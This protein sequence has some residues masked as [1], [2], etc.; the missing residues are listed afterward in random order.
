MP[1]NYLFLIFFSAHLGLSTR[2]ASS[3][4]SRDV[5]TR[6]SH[7][8][9]PAASRSVLKRSRLTSPIGRDSP[10]KK[11]SKV[12]SGMLRGRPRGIGL[13]RR[14]PSSPREIEKRRIAEMKKLTTTDG[15]WAASSPA[16]EG[17]SL[18]VKRRSSSSKKSSTTTTPDVSPASATRKKS[19]GVT[20][21]GIGSALQIKST[22]SEKEQSAGNIV[23]EL[24]RL[25]TTDGF[26]SP[27]SI[28]SDSRDAS[29][30][31]TSSSL[32]RSF[33]QR[34]QQKKGI[35]EV[36]NSLASENQTLTA[37][38]TP[39]VKQKNT[40]KILVRHSSAPDIVSPE[41]EVSK[42][43]RS[44]TSRASFLS[45]SLKKKSLLRRSPTRFGK[46]K[47]AYHR[48]MLSS[49]KFIATRRKEKEIGRE[50]VESPLSNE[51]SEES[52]R[53]L[54]RRKLDEEESKAMEDVKNSHGLRRR[55]S[56]AGTATLKA[57]P[58]HLKNKKPVVDNAN[59][60]KEKELSKRSQSAKISPASS[61]E[62]RSR[63]TEVGLKTIMLETRQ[64]R[65]KTA[66]DEIHSKASGKEKEVLTARTA[67]ETDSLRDLSVVS[68]STPNSSS[69]LAISDLLGSGELKRLDTTPGFW[70]P[71]PD[72]SRVL[73]LSY[74]RRSYGSSPR[75]SRHAAASKCNL[76]P[77][78]PKSSLLQL[79][80]K[81]LSALQKQRQIKKQ[82]SKEEQ[83]QSDCL[84]QQ[85]TED[86]TIKKK[87]FVFGRK[88]R[89]HSKRTFLKEE[90]LS[91]SLGSSSL[92]GHEGKVE[93]VSESTSDDKVMLSV[94]KNSSNLLVSQS[95][96]VNDPSKNFESSFNSTSNSVTTIARKVE[97][98]T[99]KLDSEDIS[100]GANHD[101]W[102]QDERMS[103]LNDAT[104]TYE[105][106]CDKV[107]KFTFSTPKKV[108]PV[109]A[110]SVS[111]VSTL[112]DTVETISVSH[113]ADK[114]EDTLKIGLMS[115]ESPVFDKVKAIQKKVQAGSLCN[116][117]TVTDTAKL[118]QQ[119][120]EID[121]PSKETKDTDK[122]EQI[123][124]ELDAGPQV[125]K[126]ETI[127]ADTKNALNT[128]DE[129][130][131][132]ISREESDFAEN[133]I[134]AEYKEKQIASCKVQN[135][136]NEFEGKVSKAKVSNNEKEID[137]PDSV[138]FSEVDSN[139]SLLRTDAGSSIVKVIDENQYLKDA[140]S[141][142]K[143]NFTK[144][145]SK[146]AEFSSSKDDTKA[147]ISRKEA[148]LL[149]EV[150]D[151]NSVALGLVKEMKT[152]LSTS[153]ESN[154]VP[155]DS[156]MAKG[157]IDG[158]KA[159]TG[160]SLAKHFEAK[161]ADSSIKEVETA[162]ATSVFNGAENETVA[163]VIEEESETKTVDSVLSEG[164]ETNTADF[165]SKAGVETPATDVE[166]ETAD[167]LTKEGLEVKIAD[168]LFTEGTQT[169]T[170]ESVSNNEVKKKA[171]E[172]K[173]QAVN[174]NLSCVSNVASV[175]KLS[176]EQTASAGYGESTS[177]VVK[178]NEILP[179]SPKSSF[180]ESHDLCTNPDPLPPEDRDGNET[181]Q[182][183]QSRQDIP[184][185]PK[186][187]L[188]SGSSKHDHKL[189][190]DNDSK[191]FPA[192]VK[193]DFAGSPC[194][195]SVCTEAPHTTVHTGIDLEATPEKHGSQIHTG[196]A[197]LAS[198][199]LQ[200]ETNPPDNA[201]KMFNENLKLIESNL[202][203]PGAVSLVETKRGP[204][205]RVVKR[206]RNAWKRGILQKVTK[207]YKKS[208]QNSQTVPDPYLQKSAAKRDSLVGDREITPLQDQSLVAHS[209]T[210]TN[211][212]R[213]AKKTAKEL[214]K[215]TILR[216]LQTDANLAGGSLDDSA[217]H[218][219]GRNL[220]EIVPKCN[221]IPTLR[222]ELASNVNVIDLSSK[223]KI[224]SGRG[225]GRPRKHKKPRNLP[226]LILSTKPVEEMNVHRR[227]YKTPPKLS[228][229]PIERVQT[230]LGSPDKHAMSHQ[231]EGFVSESVD[232]SDLHLYLSGVSDEE[233][234]PAKSE[235][236]NYL[237]DAYNPLNLTETFG[238]TERVKGK[239]CDSAGSQNH[240]YLHVNMVSPQKTGVTKLKGRKGRPPGTPM[241]EEEK[242]KVRSNLLAR[243]D[244]STNF[245][246]PRTARKSTFTPSLYLT[247]SVSSSTAK[248]F[249]LRQKTTR[250]PLE[251]LEIKR[252]QEEAIYDMEQE[253]RL[254]KRIN[255][256]EKRFSQ[257][258]ADELFEED[259]EDSEWEIKDCAVILNDFVKKLHLEG[260]DMPPLADASAVEGKRPDSPDYIPSAVDEDWCAN[261][262]EFQ[263][264][265]IEEWT[266]DGKQQEKRPFIPRLKLKRVPKIGKEKKVKGH[267]SK[268]RPKF[269]CPQQDA[270]QPLK[271]VIKTE[272]PSSTN[273]DNIAKSAPAVDVLNMQRQGFEGS[274]V[275]FLRGKTTNEF[276]TPKLNRAS[277]LKP[278]S[279]SPTEISEESCGK[280][281]DG[282]NDGHLI[283][284]LGD[285]GCLKS[286]S[287][288]M[289]KSS[290]NSGSAVNSNQR[291]NANDDMGA[292]QSSYCSQ[293]T[294]DGNSDNNPN[295]D[296]GAAVECQ[297]AVAQS[298]QEG[299]PKQTQE[300]SSNQTEEAA[301]SEL[302][303]HSQK[304]ASFT[305]QGMEVN[306]T[307]PSEVCTTTTVNRE[308]KNKNSTE[309]SL[310]P[311]TTNNNN[312]EMPSPKLAQQ[313]KLSPTSKSVT[314]I[315]E[316]ISLTSKRPTSCSC[317]DGWKVKTI[318]SPD[319][320]PL[321]RKFTCKRC[322]FSTFSHLTIESHI[323]S[324]IPGV[325]FR[326][327]Y[328]KSEFS[329]MAATASH[330]K[331]THQL[332]EACL[333]ISRYVEEHNFYDAEDFHTAEVDED[334]PQAAGERVM[335][336]P[337]GG[338]QVAGSVV[339]T[340]GDGAG[341]GGQS[342]PVVI[343]VL[344][345]SG[346]AATTA[347]GSH[348]T[349]VMVRPSN[350][351]PSSTTPPSASNRRRYVC[352]HCGF[353][354][355]VHAD[356][357]HHVS[358]LHPASSI[359]ACTL[360]KENTF[361]SDAEIKQHAA[362][363]HP[364]RIR[365]YRRLPDFYDAEK[366]S[367][368]VNFEDVVVEMAGSVFQD[369][370][371]ADDSSPVDHRQRAKDYLHLQEG[372]KEKRSAEA[373]STT[374]VDYMECEAD[375]IQ[376]ELADSA[377]SSQTEAE[378]D[379]GSKEGENLRSKDSEEAGSV[380]AH[381]LKDSDLSDQ[382]HISSSAA[383]SSGTE[384]D[385]VSVEEESSHH[386][387]TKR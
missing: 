284:N 254:A 68:S 314:P 320:Q 250:S 5:G 133:K 74:N 103:E 276:M 54:R 69:K 253:K 305:S 41:K 291:P 154:S 39:K 252:K 283:L 255:R 172:S 130:A 335:G 194:S 287:I 207:I 164:I 353:S 171:E 213:N 142:K 341:Q 260:L 332:G 78:K 317:P 328:C 159:N 140:D 342:P 31:S 43:S 228:P 304:N 273:I 241:T 289:K 352:T 9:S 83:Q 32:E 153:V 86:E 143:D 311:T 118:I 40:S 379:T 122:S 234:S 303:A 80:K 135:E 259:C 319:K 262:E 264:D 70:A 129:I 357:E 139:A 76:S 161:T 162:T 1:Y 292:M 141:S 155:S 92:N 99:N 50:D 97:S 56:L 64:T 268:K 329:S 236:G 377:V 257:A 173:I 346:A 59:D 57:K 60:E 183:D 72:V 175:I 331:N 52:K 12:G 71:T 89:K 23:S 191:A 338:T 325:Q 368:A 290:L 343:S 181:A 195:S 360:C 20:T 145:L 29:P 340:G 233:P 117:S 45:N 96:V 245:K 310:K 48:G 281:T 356:A 21:V 199:S 265:C 230:S 242:M 229:Q 177:L 387:T 263:D 296:N 16:G 337:R 151:S 165:V 272:V 196:S 308:S 58:D 113:V 51:P 209:Q 235:D 13:R 104:V 26:W 258:S 248:K 87:R 218:S 62:R 374:A 63:K 339:V 38:N 288:S 22:K 384:K 28:L 367:T 246:R 36:I 202:P 222:K 286:K 373:D 100:T 363:V 217:L 349:G 169:K 274:F 347:G 193:D 244:D 73:R 365:P 277:H 75:P 269:I 240:V 380:D 298:T 17:E 333:H 345:S 369:G 271:L 156:T 221:T 375:H 4:S 42:R 136:S 385:A 94:I 108:E 125:L 131:L 105:V 282:V 102:N 386:G 225:P 53:N 114:V 197:S 157:M 376:D 79:R 293:E 204:L 279:T 266:S 98:V 307:P 81:K 185:P 67:D 226:K 261:L 231:D 383:C 361:Y 275:D 350:V 93:H 180:G 101:K 214:R 313:A 119:K 359:F 179:N 121:P 358:D 166:I 152:P 312:I 65:L 306:S 206:K 10:D 14:P 210:L 149:M 322:V 25:Q 137:E 167:S 371:V 128:D 132:Q 77:P 120:M 186:L 3:L 239:E 144:L 85:V 366:L 326:C 66:G 336:S 224:R 330:I 382:T 33:R 256:L 364:S 351:A 212:V 34:S 107:D 37:N 24:R 91:E 88:K 203:L 95:K 27:G 44:S 82:I 160:D 61:L 355:N 178:S 300:L 146:D 124:D 115:K 18:Q 6:R 251:M 354:T 285:V 315:K 2:K 8:A 297:G 46:Q 123:E 381:C 112:A 182:R 201:S 126:D 372:L 208:V 309:I 90:P 362:T 243:Y 168:S 216:R 294:Q 344:V 205:R 211:T 302:V 323:Y 327:A 55:H 215:S 192:E 11:R 110:R 84:H 299:H 170:A 184:P 280:E 187:D 316:G 147:N 249:S 158:D 148:S 189:L 238:A 295:K 324:H 176:T 174:L 188:N 47:V 278:K 163:S 7:S 138:I 321:G 348:A 109:E 219:G 15:F 106:Y 237:I 200:T 30:S 223:P 111:I 232:E 134:E 198:E 270:Q 19:V 318:Q 127:F 370:H 190:I 334:Q 150:L 220:R 267:K 35:G 301:A 378:A 49:G 227:W 116:A 247:S